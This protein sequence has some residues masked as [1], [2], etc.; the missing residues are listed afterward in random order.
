[1]AHCIICNK[2]LTKN[3]ILTTCCHSI[4]LECAYFETTNTCPLDG[5]QIVKKID[6]KLCKF[7]KR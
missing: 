6:V 4:H 5:S 1:M 7:V 2:E 3:S